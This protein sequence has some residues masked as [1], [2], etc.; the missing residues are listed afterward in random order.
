MSAA[1]TIP[2]ARAAVDASG[3][4][5]VMVVDYDLSNGD[6]GL[7]FVEAMRA[8]GAQSSVVMV[9][10]STNAEAIA[11]LRGSGLPWL[12]KPVDPTAL[13]STLI[14]AIGR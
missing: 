1:S 14:H 5:E 10:G 8:K 3:P 11:A 4:P 9:T 12:T 2:A 7:K 6:T 13:R